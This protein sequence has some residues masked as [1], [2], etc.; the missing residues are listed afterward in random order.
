MNI[1]ESLTVRKSTAVL[2]IGTIR[3]WGKRRFKKIPKGWVPVTEKKSTE[4]SKRELKQFHKKMR[5]KYGGGWVGELLLRGKMKLVNAL[6]KRGKAQVTR[7]NSHFKVM[8]LKAE[9]EKALILRKAKYTKRWKGKDG[10]WHYE[11]GKEVK[12][13]T[14]KPEESKNIKDVQSIPQDIRILTID[15]VTSLIKQNA[16]LLLKKL[17]ENQDT[18]AY[19]KQQAYKQKN[20]K[21]FKRLEVMENIYTAAVDI[22][23]FRFTTAKAW[24]KEIIGKI[25]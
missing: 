5:T 17:R 6:V 10:K 3:T 15:S 16:K 1:K 4:I 12:K 18:V 11:Y 21:A 24:A 2:P 22:K 19:Q 9:E 23:E 14:K 13:V 8:F 7:A 20:A 25:N